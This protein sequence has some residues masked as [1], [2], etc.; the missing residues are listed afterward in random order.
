MQFNFYFRFSAPLEFTSRERV[1]LP[2][3]PSSKAFICRKFAVIAEKQRPETVQQLSN[4]QGVRPPHTP[5]D[6][7]VT[8]ERNNGLYF[9]HVDM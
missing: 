9:V 5:H 3:S 1:L 4:S 2:A 7:S 6:Y 8:V